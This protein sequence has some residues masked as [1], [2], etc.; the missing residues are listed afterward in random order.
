MSLR[1]K[2]IGGLLWSFLQK[3]GGQ[4]ISFLVTIVLA[5]VLLPQ[6]FGLIGMITI[7]ST[8]GTS[9]MDSGMTA[10]LIREADPDQDDYSTVFFINLLVSCLVY[11]ILFTSAPL[12]ATFFNQPLLIDI[13]R[14][15]FISL[16]IRAFSMV[17]STRLTRQMDFKTQMTIT[18]PSLIIGGVVGIVM[19]YNGYGVW[20]LVWMYLI[21]T[22][23]ETVQLW[24]RTAWMPSFV[25]NSAKFK[26]HFNFGYKLTISA[27]VNTVSNNIYNVVIGKYFSAAQLG[28][29]TMANN[30]KQVP[31]SNL[32]SV[33]NQVT[34]PLFAS[35]QDNSVKLKSVYQRLMRQVIFWIAP[36]LTIAGV[37]AEPL[38]RFVLTEKWLPAVPYF[39]IL[40]ITGIMYPLHSYN[41][42]ILKVKGRSDLFLKLE[43]IKK[44]SLLPVIVISINFGIYG[45]L[46]GQVIF[47]FFA[48]LINSWYSGKM[49]DYSMGEQLADMLPI[50]LIACMAAIPAYFLA[51]FLS[52]GFG[53]FVQLVLVSAVFMTLYLGISFLTR[54]KALHDFKELILKR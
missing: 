37:L 6:E 22:L 10:S 32:S 31:V 3:A 12:I 21:Q 27:L 51:L 18:I 54:S 46:W 49:I 43:I 7:F 38:F 14:V 8:I 42:N 11:L 40:C 28:F 17:Q 50:F 4:G 53:D 48:L 30:L 5:R 13:I 47:N 45:L 44:V 20:S 39:Q 24:I 23:L 35:I 19:A 15:Y 34:Y 26:H 2:A 52:S 33:L 29:Y 41:L 16:V 1:K 36:I 9:L 25:F